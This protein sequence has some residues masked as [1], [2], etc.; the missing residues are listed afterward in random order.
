V[1]TD[2]VNPAVEISVGRDRLRF[3]V[4]LSTFGG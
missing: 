1:F 4:K 2:F 3:V